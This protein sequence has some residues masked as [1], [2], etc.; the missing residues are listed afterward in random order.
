MAR[1]WLAPE[2][3][4]DL[5]HL[6]AAAIARVKSEAWPDAAS[7]DELHDALVWLGFLTDDEVQAAPNWRGW[8]AALADQKRAASIQV[9]GSMLWIAAERLSLCRSLWPELM[10]TPQISAPPGYDKPCSSDD[11]LVEILRGRLEGLGPITG[12]ARQAARPAATG[13]RPDW[14]RSK[15]RASPCADA[16]PQARRPTN[17]A[18]AACSPASITTRSSGCARRSSPWPRAT[19][20]ASSS[21]GSALAR[22]AGRGAE[23]P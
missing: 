12:V 20:C 21:S 23:D 10:T 17:G 22:R 9:A 16:S 13:P 14:R 6:D 4:S 19:S 2:Q 5:G 15:P 11:A 3:A 1:R 8:L 18:S 7:A